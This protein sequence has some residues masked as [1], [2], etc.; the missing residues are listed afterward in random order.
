MKKYNVGDKIKTSHGEIEFLGKIRVNY[1]GEPI[2][3]WKCFCG[4]IF[5]NKN[6]RINSGHTKSCGC[7]EKEKLRNPEFLYLY[8]IWEGIKDRCYNLNSKAYKRYGGR[9]IS[10]QENWKNNKIKFTNDIIEILGHRPP[11]RHLLDR[12][13]NNGNYEINNLRWLTPAKSNLNTSRNIIIKIGCEEKTISEWSE[14]SGIA[15]ATLAYR[16]KKK[17]PEEKFLIPIIKKI[18]TFDPFDLRG[19]WHGIR[20]RI[21]YEKNISYHNYGGRGIK[22]YELWQDDYERFKN[23][24]INEIGS[25]PFENYQLHR[26]DNNGNYEPGNLA[27]VS[28]KKN[29][30]DKRTNVFVTIDGITKIATDLANEYN[31][32]YNVILRRIKNNLPQDQLLAPVI[33]KALNDQQ[34]I[35]IREKHSQGKTKISLANEY[36]VCV[37]VITDVIFCR[38]A[39]IVKD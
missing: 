36:N 31:L 26:K 25:K 22:M 23:D 29:A 9:G 39:Y 13:D 28:V 34:V 7:I 4:N 1:H 37:E 2:S 38:E 21:F 8:S 16:F 27:W 32:P 5:E 12:I 33:K 10:M 20:D 18:K 14:I 11:G 30:R 3:N 35:E 17:W 19:T 15:E 6:S 24:I